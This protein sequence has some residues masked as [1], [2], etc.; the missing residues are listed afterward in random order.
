[1]CRSSGSSTP[2]K[3]MAGLARTSSNP[4]TQGGRGVV[5]LGASGCGDLNEEELARSQRSVVHLDT[6]R[7]QRDAK[8]LQL[9]TDSSSLVLITKSSQ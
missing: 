8:N 9:L 3:T 7:S 4:L 2:K 6:R 1:M 5:Q